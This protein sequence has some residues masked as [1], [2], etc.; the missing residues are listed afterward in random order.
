MCGCCNGAI[1]TGQYFTLGTDDGPQSFHDYC[2]VCSSC[3]NPLSEASIMWHEGLLYCV[4][5]F[6]RLFPNIDVRI[7]QGTSASAATSAE[8]ARTL[9]SSES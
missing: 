4:E 3:R 5:D 6:R 1:T 2:H 8:E 9:F 7:L